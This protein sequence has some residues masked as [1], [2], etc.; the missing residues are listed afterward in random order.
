MMGFMLDMGDMGVMLL[1]TVQSQWMLMMIVQSRRRLSLHLK[2][3]CSVIFLCLFSSCCCC[4]LWTEKDHSWVD[5][6]RL[7]DK[8]GFLFPDFFFPNV[9]V[10]HQRRS[11][12][13]RGRRKKDSQ[14]WYDFLYHI[15]KKPSIWRSLFYIQNPRTKLGNWRPTTHGQVLV[16]VF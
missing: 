6:G 12:D 8:V 15:N 7:L 13:R 16:C 3:D 14:K 2:L 9:I 5:K 1:I 11:F 4:Y 10:C